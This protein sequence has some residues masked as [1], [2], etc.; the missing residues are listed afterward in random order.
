[1]G[2]RESPRLLYIN[3]GNYPVGCRHAEYKP[4]NCSPGKSGPGV[5]ARRT[6]S[7]AALHTMPCP[8]SSRLIGGVASLF[9]L[10]EI[11]VTLKRSTR[12]YLN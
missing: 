9:Y 2:S 8:S 1:M 6:V 11:G 7:Y 12:R 5:E 3:G 10:M 4:L